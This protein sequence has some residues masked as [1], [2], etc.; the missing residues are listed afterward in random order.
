MIVAKDD[1]GGRAANERSKDVARVDLD[2]GERAPGHASFQQ[3]PVPYI[4]RQHPEL[5]DRRSLQAGAI[6]RPYVGRIAKKT[7]ALRP[8]SGHAPAELDGGLDDGRAR[9]TDPRQSA[10]LG[11]PALGEGAKI[12]H[13]CQ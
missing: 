11:F 9:R 3:Y 5:L 1:R 2:S 10:E 6:V 12:A 8:R 4:E 7:A 13:A